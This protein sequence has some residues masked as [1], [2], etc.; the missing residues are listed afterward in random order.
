MRGP[1]SSRSAP[2]CT[3]WS[4]AGARSKA[5]QRWP[6]LPRSWKGSQSRQREINARVSRDLEKVILRCLRKDPERRWQAMADVKV[7]LEEAEGDPAHRTATRVS[8]WAVGKRPRLILLVAA[9]ALAIGAVALGPWW[10]SAAPRSNPRPLQTRLTSNEGWTDYPAISPDGKILAYAS[11]RSGEGNLDIWIQQIPGGPP[12]RLTRHMSDEV[13]P[14]FSADGSR[15]AFQSNRGEGGIYVI[16]TLGGEE[17][18]L[19]ERGFSPRFSPDGQWIA[20]GISESS[21]S[22]IYVMPAAGDPRSEWP[23]ISIWRVLPCG[24]PME[25]MCCSGASATATARPRTTL[26]GT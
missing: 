23:R 2:C 15:I 1:M 18:L 22:Q 21:G 24:H 10:K 11:D 5:R 8:S 26:T 19:V 25:N 9:S 14:S 13:D 17:R 6:R 3:R 16:P 12:V 7:A 4:L 20:Y